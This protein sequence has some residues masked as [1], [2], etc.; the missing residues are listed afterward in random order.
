MTYRLDYKKSFESG[1]SVCEISKSKAGI[2]IKKIIKEIGE[3]V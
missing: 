3:Y 1:K 2:E